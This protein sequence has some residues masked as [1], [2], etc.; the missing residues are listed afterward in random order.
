M[1]AAAAQTTH[2]AGTGYTATIAWSP[3]PTAGN[4]DAD[5]AFT[6]TVEFTAATGYLFES[7]FSA[8]DVTGLPATGASGTA[9]SVTVTRNSSTKVTVVAVYK[10]TAA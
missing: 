8:D 2:D 6:A 10:K 3:A 5:T 4:F 9:T 1:K 7:D